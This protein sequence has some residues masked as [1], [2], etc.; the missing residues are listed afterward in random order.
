MYFSLIKNGV[1]LATGDKKILQKELER[2]IKQRIGCN[3]I[4][5][6]EVRD[7]EKIHVCMD[8]C[9]KDVFSE[10]EINILNRMGIS[11]SNSIEGIQRLL[12]VQ[13]VQCSEKSPCFH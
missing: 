7:L 11:R 2:L 4:L 5:S 10:Y 9:N 3:L 12:N 13:I 6:I 8:A 1:T